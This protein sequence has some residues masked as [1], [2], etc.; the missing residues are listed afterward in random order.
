MGH[1]SSDYWNEALSGERMIPLL[2]LTRVIGEGAEAV[3]MVE[4]S[5]ALTCI[6]MQ[7]SVYPFFNHSPNF[8]SCDIRDSLQVHDRNKRSA[9]IKHPSN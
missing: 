2:Y 9:I 1:V 3:V 4:V 5:W 6:I 8:S 7:N